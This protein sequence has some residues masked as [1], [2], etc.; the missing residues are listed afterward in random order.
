ML[1]ALPDTRTPDETSEVFLAS[2][3]NKFDDNNECKEDADT[4]EK[5]S[6]HETITLDE[7]GPSLVILQ[8]SEA[9]GSVEI[10]KITSTVETG[11]LIF[12]GIDAVRIV[13]QRATSPF[14]PIVF[15]LSKL[16]CES[17]RFAEHKTRILSRHASTE[18]TIEH[19]CVLSRASCYRGSTQKWLLVI[20]QVHRI[21]AT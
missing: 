5:Q 19:S 16:I 3:D 7:Q 11:N 2:K 4:E 18:Q 1:N 20:V 8:K 12:V 15:F 14:D 10:C 13:S 21:E 17:I 9:S 6:I